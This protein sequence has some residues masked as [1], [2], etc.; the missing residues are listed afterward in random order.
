MGF[1]TT[2]SHCVNATAGGC[3]DP[4]TGTGL[5][6]VT[7]PDGN[8][9]VYPY[10]QGTLAATSTFTA[11]TLTSE[12]DQQPNTISGTLLDTSS[13][14]GDGNT[15][16]SYNAVGNPTSAT[17]PG[18]NG[19]PATITTAYTASLQQ[20]SCDSTTITASTATCQQDTPPAPVAPG[21]VIAPPSS[22]PRRA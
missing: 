14:N 13:T 18:A 21:G 9:T 6:T 5:V 4:A 15:T 17:S 20:P 7:G 22:A 11:S 12:T 10:Q 16:T 19:T 2:F 3:M 1:K 8:S